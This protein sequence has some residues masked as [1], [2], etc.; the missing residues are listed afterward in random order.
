M[1]IINVRSTCAT[2]LLLS[3]ALV[4]LGLR[5]QVAQQR[6][7][8]EQSMLILGLA[9]EASLQRRLRLAAEPEAPRRQRLPPALN[10]FSDKSPAP[11]PSY[12][13]SSPVYRRLTERIHTNKLQG[14]PLLIKVNSFPCAG[15]STFIKHHKGTYQNIT[16]LDYDG[17]QNGN[18]TSAG[19][20]RFKSNTALFGSAFMLRNGRNNFGRRSNSTNDVGTYENVVYVHVIP[21]LAR[22]MSNIQARQHSRRNG[23]RWSDPRNVLRERDAAL[24]IVFEGGIQVAP[25]F[26]NFGAA[27]AFCIE[28]YNP[29]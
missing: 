12:N 22:V 17:Q 2:L 20:L 24:A 15:K 28:A 11:R 5:V 21:R 23:T 6:E 10:R 19:L 16:L 7:H 3:A 27:L 9:E 14:K 4:V 25:L 1:S 29:V 13:L 18:R 8:A 26:S